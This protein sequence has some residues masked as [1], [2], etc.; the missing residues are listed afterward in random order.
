MD[1]LDVAS[2]NSEAWTASAVDNVL[3]S[4]RH[5]KP[6]GICHNCADPIETGMRFCDEDCRDDYEWR[7]Q[8]EE[9]NRR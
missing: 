3:G 5:L 8:R 4:A 6:K 9:A 2:D 7:Q 1:V